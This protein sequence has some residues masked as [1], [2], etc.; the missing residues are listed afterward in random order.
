MKK[1]LF[2]L[3]S[4]LLFASLLTFNT[5][6]TS[7]MNE[8]KNV[9]TVMSYKKIWKYKDINGK[10]HKRLWNTATQQWESEWI[11]V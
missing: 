11:P 10:L 6:F 5:N 8:H 7:I 4:N 2:I 9:Y 1:I 3:C